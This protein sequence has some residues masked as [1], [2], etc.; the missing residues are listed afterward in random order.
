MWQR[1]NKGDNVKKK[2]TLQLVT[3]W[4]LGNYRHNFG[5]S[6]TDFVTLFGI[7]K[8][9]TGTMKANDGM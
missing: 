4:L 5:E 8:G 1:R 3:D 9:I 7:S 2:N 6:R